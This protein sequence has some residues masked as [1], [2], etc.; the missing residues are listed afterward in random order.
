[1]QLNFKIERKSHAELVM[2]IINI[3]RLIWETAVERFRH[4]ERMVREPFQQVEVKESSLRSA[5]KEVAIA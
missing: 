1:M 5:S 4:R 3:D 2:V